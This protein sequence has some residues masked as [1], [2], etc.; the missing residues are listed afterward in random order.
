MS[1]GERKIAVVMGTRPEGIKLAPVIAALARRHV[2]VPVII[3]TG[4]HREMLAQALELFDLRPHFDL[5]VMSQAQ[6]L[7]DVTCRTLE[8]L[9]PVL[10]EVMPEWIVVQG[11]TTT[12]LA[13][14][15]AGFYEKLPV[16]HV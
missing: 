8:R 13:A 1:I 4:Q 3:S 5:G 12:A 2:A 10:L 7:H 14:A 16:A 6:S 9:R 15:L 11:D